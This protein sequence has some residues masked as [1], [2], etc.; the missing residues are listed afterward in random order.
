MKLAEHTHIQV[1]T[2]YSLDATTQPSS[3]QNI[4]TVVPL[5]NKHSWNQA[6]VSLHWGCPRIRVTKWG[7]QGGVQKMQCVMYSVYVKRRHSHKTVNIMFSNISILVQV[8]RWHVCVIVVGSHKHWTVPGVQ[9]CRR[10]TRK[11]RHI[12]MF[13]MVLRQQVK[14]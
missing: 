5:F 2:S 1:G 14:T 8:L 7:G 9:G 10:I 11:T 3:W 13:I 4:H 12:K 6:K